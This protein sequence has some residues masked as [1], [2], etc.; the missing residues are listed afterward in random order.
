MQEDGEE[1]VELP[2]YNHVDK[3]I[4]YPAA[5]RP[6]PAKVTKAPH[7]TGFFNGGAA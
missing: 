5:S 7:I 3:T 4:T 6:L 2:T 1:A